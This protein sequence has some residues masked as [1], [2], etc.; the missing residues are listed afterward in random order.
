MAATEGPRGHPHAYLLWALVPSRVMRGA[1]VAETRGG[2]L[3]H[4]RLDRRNVTGILE[5]VEQVLPHIFLPGALQ[6][7]KAPL[8]A[9]GATQR[10]RNAL[11]DR[12][13]VRARRHLVVR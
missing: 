3:V 6:V 7:I 2:L 11:A 9:T 4:G 10:L 13:G 1:L 8:K 5:E 12:V